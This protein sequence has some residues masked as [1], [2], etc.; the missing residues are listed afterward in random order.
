VLEEGRVA[1]GV[2]AEDDVVGEEPDHTLELGSVA[3]GHRCPDYD[4][5]LARVGVERRGE[6][7]QQHHE[8][9]GVGAASEVAHCL[10]RGG[11]DLEPEVRAGRGLHAGP[12]PVGGQLEGRRVGEDPA[13]VRDQPVEDLVAQ[14]VA[15]PQRV[16]GVLQRGCRQ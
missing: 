16:V 12:R 4:V 2:G 3:A 15:L 7:R 6:R 9:G 8:R 5:V 10:Y 14:L 1:A 13:P 11:V